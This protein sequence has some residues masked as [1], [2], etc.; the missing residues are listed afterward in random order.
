[1][2][3][4]IDNDSSV[5]DDNLNFILDDLFGPINDPILKQEDEA[6]VPSM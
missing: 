5:L 3:T 1:M 2:Q 6:P 4:S